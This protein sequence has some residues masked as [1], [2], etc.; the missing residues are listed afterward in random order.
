MLAHVV[1]VYLRKALRR[2]PLTRETLVKIVAGPIKGSRVTVALGDDYY[3][4]IYESDTLRVAETKIR[5]QDIVYDIGANAGYLTM[6]FA[7]KCRCVHAF[8]PLERNIHRWKK[9]MEANRVTNAI[10]HPYA[11]SDCDRELIFAVGHSAFSNRY[12]RG[13]SEVG[14]VSVAGRSLDSLVGNRE[15]P[16]PDVIKIDVEGAELDVLHGAANTI[17]AYRPLIF[18]A[19]HDC[20]NPGVQE[21]CLSHLNS[22]GYQC[23]ETSEVKVISGLSDYICVP[24]QGGGM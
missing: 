5:P 21:S 23:Q 17:E 16:P 14:G 6:A 13:E 20:H 22:I 1:G 18:L 10:L 9:H 12:E 11:I 19:T 4:G 2:F 24:L 15:L 3:L 8:E 7:R